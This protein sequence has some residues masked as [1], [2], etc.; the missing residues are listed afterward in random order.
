MRG[1]QVADKPNKSASAKY[2]DRKSN[3]LISAPK[4]V[5]KPSVL[6]YRVRWAWPG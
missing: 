2:S 3:V 4:A 6:S 1:A 5:G